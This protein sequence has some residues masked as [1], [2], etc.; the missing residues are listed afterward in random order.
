ML[1]LVLSD[2]HL[3]AGIHTGGVYIENDC[4]AAIDAVASKIKDVPI[5]FALLPGD[6]FNS[7]KADSVEL[8]LASYLIKKLDVPCY[9][10]Q[11]NHDRGEYNIMTVCFD[12]VDLNNET[13]TLKDGTKIAGIKH[14]ENREEMLQRLD[15]L[16]PDIDILLCHLPV[17]PFST[18]NGSLQMAAADIAKGLLTI[19]GDTHITDAYEFLRNPEDPSSRAIVLS[20]GFLYP[21]NKTELMTGN[22]GFCFIDTQGHGKMPIIYNV[23]LPKRQAYEFR[24]FNEKAFTDIAE[25]HKDELTPIVYVPRHIVQQTME[26]NLRIITVPVAVRV[27]IDDVMTHH[28]HSGKTLRERFNELAVACSLRDNLPVD[29]VDIA[30]AL[31]FGSD[32]ANYM[33]TIMQQKDVKG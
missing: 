32:P 4:K 3:S 10:I 23:S 31:I 29:V 5:E 27:V 6:V 11:G 2:L 17:S 15:S 19:V 22:P 25:K 1:G 9:V 26:L 20:P 12:C 7:T 33:E 24:D 16:D 14:I 8:K 30:D 18:F 28:E 21:A 13:V